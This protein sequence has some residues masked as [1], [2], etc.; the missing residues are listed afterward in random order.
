MPFEPRRGPRAD[1]RREREEL[2]LGQTWVGMKESGLVVSK[3]IAAIE[4]RQVQMRVA[5]QR[6]GEPLREEQ[7]TGVQ[8]GPR[9]Q[10][11]LQSAVGLEAQRIPEPSGHARVAGAHQRR[12]RAIDEITEP[13]LPVLV[14]TPGP[15]V[16]SLFTARE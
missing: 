8:L 10:A 9:A 7:A 3:S 5:R 4:R 11:P 1:P 14:L 12:S 2:G 16:P 15:R 13:E 6:P